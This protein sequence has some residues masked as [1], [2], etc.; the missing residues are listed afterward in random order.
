MAQVRTRRAASAAIRLWIGGG[1]I[2]RQ[3]A[4]VGFPTYRVYEGS[5]ADESNL[6][7]LVVAAEADA[8]AGALKVEQARRRVL[9]VRGAAE[10]GPGF[11]RRRRRRK[12]SHELDTLQAPTTTAPR[13]RTRLDRLKDGPRPH[14]PPRQVADPAFEKL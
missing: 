10:W 1:H 7:R 12:S 4:H 13:L 5:G 14:H 11:N 6:N 3:P 8:A 2:V 9:A